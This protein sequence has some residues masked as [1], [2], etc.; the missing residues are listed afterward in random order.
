MDQAGVKWR[1]YT[2]TLT[3]FW[4]T[5]DAIRHIR[6]GPDWTSDII[7]PETT[8]LSDIQTGNLQQVSWVVPKATNSDHPSLKSSE[9]P[10]WIASVVN[11]VGLSPYWNNT[12]IIITWDEHGGWFEHVQPPSVDIIGLGLRVPLIVV[13]PW[14][15]HGYVSHVQH[16]HASIVH[17]VED[18]FSLPSIGAADARADDLSDCF[19]FTQVPPPFKP[20]ASTKTVRYFER[21][22]SSSVPPDNDGGQP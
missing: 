1:Y 14:A 6:Y 13:S 18:V 11:A 9:G 5:Y 3:N 7:T 16:E 20:I 15:R 21:Q 12:A 19:D 4:N 17:F 8:I 10:E 2:P 22:P